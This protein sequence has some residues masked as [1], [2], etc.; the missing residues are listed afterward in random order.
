MKINNNININYIKHRFFILSI[1][2]TLFIKKE[3]N[4]YFFFKE[5]NKMLIDGI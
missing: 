1:I 5:H 2:H 4:Y 3:Y